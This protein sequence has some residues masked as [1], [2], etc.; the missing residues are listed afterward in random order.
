MKASLT[1]L[2]PALAVFLGSSSRTIAEDVPLLV[3]A[4]PSVS[5]SEL[6]ADK[7]EAIFTL[8]ERQ[9]PG[10][11]TIIAFNYPPGSALRESF[12]RVVLRM[13]PDDVARFWI[14][15]RIRGLGDSPRKVPTAALLLRIVANLRGAIGYVPDGPLPADVKL[16][17]RISAGKVQRVGG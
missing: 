3:I 15:R 7:L 12:D 13:G 2:L 6:S 17:A 9:W 14:D 8:S 1:W 11:D 10:G 16:V 4:N 5:A